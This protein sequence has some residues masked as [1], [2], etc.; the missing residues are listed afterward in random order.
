M[1][2]SGGEGNVEVSRCGGEGRVGVE[3]KKSGNAPF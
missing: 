2:A 1:L 3:M